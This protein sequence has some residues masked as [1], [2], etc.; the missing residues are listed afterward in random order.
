LDLTAKLY[1]HKGTEVVLEAPTYLA[2]LQTFQFFGADCLA[3]AMESD[4]PDLAALRRHL[5]AYTPAFI[6]L[7]PTFQNPSALR[8][9]EAK[10]EAVAA[11]LD[12]F[13]VTLIKDEPYRELTFKGGSALPIVSRLK[14]ASWIYTGTVSKTVLPGLRVGY[15]MRA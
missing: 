10:R 11:L 13:G 2:A 7:I 6:Y 14:N 8:Y 1:I 15:L 12:E 5:E 9:S 4:G 3:V